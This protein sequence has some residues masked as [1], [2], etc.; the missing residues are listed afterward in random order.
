MYKCEHICFPTPRPSHTLHATGKLIIKMSGRVKPVSSLP[1]IYFDLFSE[2]YH[3][4]MGDLSRH[5]I[6]NDGVPVSWIRR[7]RLLAVVVGKGRLG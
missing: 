7:C 1:N 5:D 2:T 6:I 4:S 3:Q